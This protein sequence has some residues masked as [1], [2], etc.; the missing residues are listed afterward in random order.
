[1]PGPADDTARPPVAQ[2]PALWSDAAGSTQRGDVVPLVDAEARHATGALRLRAGDPITL[3]DGRGGVASATMA[4]VGRDAVTVRVVDS[5]RLAPLRPRLELFV[6]PP[7]GPRLEAMI[8]QLVQVGVDAVTLLDTQRSVAS[9]SEHRQRRLD[10]A[11]IE[12]C[13][14]CGR[15]WA[16]DIAG[17]IAF[18]HAIEAATPATPTALDQRQARRQAPI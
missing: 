9:P 5:Q 16:M 11:V 6:A 14:Q 17:P 13:K 3:L 10:K 15:A 12:A 1:V 7:K 2:G 8:N 4:T 18:D